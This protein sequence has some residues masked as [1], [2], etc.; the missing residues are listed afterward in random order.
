MAVDVQNDFYKLTDGRTDNLGGKN[1]ALRA[2][3]SSFEAELFSI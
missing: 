3:N 2:E 1:R